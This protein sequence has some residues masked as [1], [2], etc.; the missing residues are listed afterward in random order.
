MGGGPTART[1][2]SDDRWVPHFLF[3]KVQHGSSFSVKAR[4]VKLL[5]QRRLRPWYSRPA[6]RFGS[7]DCHIFAL[8]L[9]RNTFPWRI[10]TMLR[11]RCPEVGVKEIKL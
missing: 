5:I 9:T 10:A 1:Q 4:F 2:G 7:S 6:S 3:V 8:H 11:E